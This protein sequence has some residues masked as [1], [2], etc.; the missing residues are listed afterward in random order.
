MANARNPILIATATLVNGGGA[1]NIEKVISIEKSGDASILFIYDYDHTEK[2]VTWEFAD[3][4]TRDTEYDGMTVASDVFA[5]GTQGAF[6]EPTA[7]TVVFKTGVAA[8]KNAINLNKVAAISTVD[9]AAN[10]L[11]TG[12]KPMYSIKFTYTAIDTIKETSWH[13][14]NATDRDTTYGEITNVIADVDYI[15][16]V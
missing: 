9:V 14:D 15:T 5:T 16:F 10:F 8:V 7:A 11:G 12:A 2:N 6:V 1:V 13:F 4:A 3:T